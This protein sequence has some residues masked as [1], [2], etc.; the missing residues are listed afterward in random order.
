MQ[1][2]AGILIAMQMMTLAGSPFSGCLLLT[3]GEKLWKIGL[4]LFGSV[5][6]G[7]WCYPRKQRKMKLLVQRD[8]QIQI[9]TEI[10]MTPL[11]ECSED[12]EYGMPTKYLFE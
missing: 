5:K 9:S 11:N 3:S 6:M 10:F 2:C 7:N 4:L 12:A 8:E 1:W